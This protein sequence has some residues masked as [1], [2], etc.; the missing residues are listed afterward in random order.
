M[1]HRVTTVDWPVMLQVLDV[2]DADLSLAGFSV[3]LPRPKNDIAAVSEKVAQLIDEV[4]TRSE[5][6]LREQAARFDGVR[7]HALKVS[8]TDR[9]EALRQVDP[10]LLAAMR[11][12]IRRVRLASQAQLP[13]EVTTDIDAETSITQRYLPV[14]R[15]GVYVPGGKAVYPSSVIMNV[16]PAQVAGVRSIALASPAQ[17]EFDG[18]VHPTI[19]AAAALLDV[20][21]IYAIGGVGAIASFA[22]GVDEIGLAPVDVVTGPGNT[23]VAAAKRQLAGQVGIDA[24]AGAT[25]VLV[26]ADDQA[27]PRFVAADLISQAEHDESAAAILVTDSSVF[28]DRVIAELEPLVSEQLHEARIRQSL[29]G[30]Q[31][32]LVLVDSLA[33][34]YR[35]SNL[36]APEH[37]ELH[38]RNVDV[39][40]ECLTNAGV[41]FVG[42][43]A[44]VAVG[45][46]IAGSNHVLPTGGTARFSSGLNVLSFMRS[47]QVVRVSA[48]GLQQLEEPLVTLAEA[49]QL[50]AHASSVTIRHRN[51]EQG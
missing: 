12:S 41:I 48:R 28:A 8:M 13:A 31:S 44:P 7:N 30:A 2:R 15:A 51:D 4:K 38:V 34:A 32:R 47:Q 16:V 26:I 10:Q 20:T 11:E 1:L 45:D 24:E 36:Y 6:A 22:F 17:A 37:L 27:N 39:A 23:Y 14:A 43:H 3:E 18:G 40:L 33:S 19:L 25:E 49:E 35:F 50:P 29:S 42:E 46:Y 5:A 9:N 21:E